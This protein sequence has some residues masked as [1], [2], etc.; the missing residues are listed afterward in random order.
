MWYS[1]GKKK[2][3][4]IKIDDDAKIIDVIERLGVPVEQINFI[5]KNDQK[6][7]MDV[8]M[9]EGDQIEIRPIIAGG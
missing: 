5:L 8:L 7:D 2:V 9:E 4:D 6:V 1:E 3:H